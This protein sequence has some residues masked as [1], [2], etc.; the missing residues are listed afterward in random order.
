MCRFKRHIK[1]F[2]NVSTVL[3]KKILIWREN[4]NFNKF[5]FEN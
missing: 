5:N 4:T 2:S 3:L 1:L